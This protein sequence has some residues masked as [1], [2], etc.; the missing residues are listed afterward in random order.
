MAIGWGRPRARTEGRLGVGDG[1]GW[2]RTHAAEEARDLAE[3][4]HGM[5]CARALFEFVG[6]L[7]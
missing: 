5:P 6:S 2:G 3:G 7:F 1:S 4:T